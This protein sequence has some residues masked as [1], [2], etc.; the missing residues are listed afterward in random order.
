M[1]LSDLE[2]RFICTACGKRD[3]IIRSADVSPK[4]GTGG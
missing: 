2:P 3:S 1:R 4:M